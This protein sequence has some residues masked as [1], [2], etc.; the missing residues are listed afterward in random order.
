MTISTEQFTPVRTG[1]VAN[2]GTGDSLRE[3]FVK[4]NT[5]FSNISDI[6][7]D[8]GNINVAGAVEIAGN[9][10]IDNEYVPTTTGSDG[11]AGQI[12]WDSSYIYVCV[13]TNSWK[14]ANLA[15]W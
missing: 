7:F 15:A 10:S 14:R 13:A 5:N 12:V 2:D 8:A 6:G 3:A 1:T 4:V 11:T 9:L